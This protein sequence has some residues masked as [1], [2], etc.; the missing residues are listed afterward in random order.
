M[1]TLTPFFAWLKEAALN[2]F[3]VLQGLFL[4][5]VAV[6]LLVLAIVGSIIWYFSTIWSKKQ[7]ARDIMIKSGNFFF[8]IA[9]AL[10]HLG[11]VACGGFL[12]WLLLKENSPMPFGVPGESVSEILGWNYALD[13]LSEWGLNLR[14]DLNMIDRD[15][16]ED[17]MMSA[18]YEAKHLLD[19]YKLLQVK[20]ETIENTKDFMAKYT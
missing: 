7:K 14:H 6:V 12:N 18:I 16:C 5:I 11:N 2:S 9:L 15:H 1:K 13:N 17:A 19:K 3:K 4:I 8:L 10:D 20:L